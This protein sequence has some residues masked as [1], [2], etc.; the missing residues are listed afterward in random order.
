MMHHKLGLKPKIVRRESGDCC[1]WCKQVEGVYEYPNVPRDVYRRHRY[2]RCTVEYSPGDGKIQNVHTKKWID[3]DKD[4]K[5]EKRKQANIQVK[6]INRKD[7]REQFEKYLDILGKDRMPKSLSEFQKLKYENPK[8]YERLLR[9][10]ETISKINAKT[11]SNEFKKK[12]KDVYYDFIKQ[13]HEFTMHGCE[14]FIKRGSQGKYTKEEVLNVLNKDFNFRQISDNRPVKYYN[15]IQIIY[16]ENKV[17]VLNVIK[18]GENFN[19]ME[20]FYEYNK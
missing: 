14:R 12:V 5:I 11:W 18:R 10:K 8:E 13:N 6:D 3:P 15:D 16:L 17:E 7:D 1:E 20:A 2:C 19:I 4:D 9:E